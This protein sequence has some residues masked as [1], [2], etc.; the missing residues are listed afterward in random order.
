MFSYYFFTLFS[1]PFDNQV[2]ALHA[3]T[4]TELIVIAVRSSTDA[5]LRPHVITTSARGADF[6]RMLTG[7]EIENVAVKFEAYCL[8]GVQGL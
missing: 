1:R 5:Y 6:F 2:H 8:S 3:R 7:Q 4:N